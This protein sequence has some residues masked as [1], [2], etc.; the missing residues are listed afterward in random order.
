MV[1][2]LED[3]NSSEKERK[4]LPFVTCGQKNSSRG[5]SAC[6]SSAEGWRAKGL[7]DNSVALEQ[8]QLGEGYAERLGTVSI[9]PSIQSPPHTLFTLCQRGLGEPGPQGAQSLS[10]ATSLL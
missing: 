10:A 3:N 2:F 9:P 1:F 7:C 6:S 4:A 5:N 8:V